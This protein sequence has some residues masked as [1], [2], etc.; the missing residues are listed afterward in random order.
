MS[1]GSKILLVVL[2]LV[3]LGGVAIL[4]YPAVATEMVVRRYLE[5]PTR[6]VPYDEMTALL[7]YI[8][9]CWPYRFAGAGISK[10]REAALVEAGMETVIV[11]GDPQVL[12]AVTV[13]WMMDGSF[14]QLPTAVNDKIIEGK[15][16]VSAVIC[17]VGAERGTLDPYIDVDYVM[18]RCRDER[19][20]VAC[21]AVLAEETLSRHRE[22]CMK[23]LERRD[24]SEM[25]KRAMMERMERGPAGGQ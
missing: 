3:L 18:L 13:K 14:S 1:T 8:G 22:S 20:I 11:N 6:P 21:C 2:G 24:L 23:M 16:G 5:D 10:E 25:P 7:A 12:T 9:D 17:T 4:V 19:V 15:P